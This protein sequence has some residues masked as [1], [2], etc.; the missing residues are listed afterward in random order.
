MEITALEPRR[1]SL[2]AVYID[3]E[4]ALK[5]DTQ[6]LLE[7]RI[8]IG[9]V[10][11]DE[12]LKEL[13]EKSN[14]RRAKEKALWLI[15]YRDHSKKEL[16]DKI[17]K[18]C[19]RT[20]AEAAVERMQELGLVNDEAYAR[21]YAQQLFEVKHLS[22]KGVKYKLIEKGIDRDLI[23]DILSEFDVDPKEQIREIIDKK[24]ARCLSDEKGK[25]RAFSG[26]S[27]MGF[28]FGDIKSVIAEYTDNDEY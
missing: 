13:I 2:T 6:T 24:Y 7:N 17:A 10:L 23:D 21:R 19:D 16:E 9:T 15:S 5:L 27:R 20:S 3:G 26:L 8:K 14:T 1:K 11:D 28:T 4:F 22:I 25:R 18:S 12:E